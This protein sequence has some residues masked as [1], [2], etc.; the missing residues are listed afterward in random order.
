MDAQR[1]AGGAQGGAPARQGLTPAMGMAREGG[2]ALQGQ[3]FV[4]NA[5][6]QGFVRGDQGG[7]MGFASA[8]TPRSGQSAPTRQSCR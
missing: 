6:G 3:R 1:G 2:S 4:I 8:P 7:A 5:Q